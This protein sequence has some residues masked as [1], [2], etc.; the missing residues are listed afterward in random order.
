MFP[1]D[2][3]IYVYTFQRFCAITLSCRLSNHSSL[4]SHTHLVP[5]HQRT[6]SQGNSPPSAS[7][8][9]IDYSPVVVPP[10]SPLSHSHPLKS[11][12]GQS[13][14]VTITTNG[15]TLSADLHNQTLLNHLCYI[16]VNHLPQHLNWTSEVSHSR[17][18]QVQVF[19]VR[20]TVLWPFPFH[21]TLHL[22]QGSEWPFFIKSDLCPSMW[23]P[24]PLHPAPFGY[25][26]PKIPPRVIASY[27]IPVETTC[28]SRNY[29]GCWHCC[30]CFLPVIT[31]TLIL[32]SYKK[33]FKLFLSS[34][35][36]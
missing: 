1:T 6:N 20:A 31:I 25:P 35:P 30:C 19:R 27:R 13:I 2:Y 11:S 7:I 14:R 24:L 17:S 15:V 32:S 28:W 5:F 9:T 29:D 34:C 21:F 10:H 36:S 4:F 23:P 8:N 18:S 16:R 3:T 22:V 33:N 26:S 12:R